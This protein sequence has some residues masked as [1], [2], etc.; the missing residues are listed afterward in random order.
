MAA[1]QDEE[2]GFETDVNELPESDNGP[3]DSLEDKLS[4]DA[5]KSD[6]LEDAQKEGAEE[7]E[8]GGLY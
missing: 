3:E 4:P 7:R 8:E 5:Q 6:D 1:P 2:P